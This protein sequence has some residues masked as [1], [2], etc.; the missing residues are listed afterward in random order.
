MLHELT[1]EQRLE[2]M[3]PLALEAWFLTGRPLP[4]YKRS[5]APVHIVRGATKSG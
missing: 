1:P 3:W 5:G 4:S 2:M